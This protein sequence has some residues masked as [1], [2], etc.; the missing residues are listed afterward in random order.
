MILTPI[1]GSLP[2]PQL[3]MKVRSRPA[4]GKGN[5]GR[6]AGSLFSMMRDRPTKHRIAF[7]TGI[8]SATKW[9]C[10]KGLQRN[11][12]EGAAPPALLSEC[13]SEPINRL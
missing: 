9:A 5:H 11:K 4:Q 12:A 1:L 13:F 3:G 6:Q 7:P 10:K 8:D 2:P